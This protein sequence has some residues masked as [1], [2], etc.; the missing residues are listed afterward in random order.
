MALVSLLVM[1]HPFYIKLGLVSIYTLALLLPFTSQFFVPATPIF[2]WL[3]VFYSSQF[4]NKEYRPHIWVSVLPTLESVLYGG[5]I[6]DLLTR[7][8]NPVLDI[9]AW[10]PYGVLHFVLPFV[11][12]A[13]LF[14]F[15]PPGAV[16]FWGAAFGYMNLFGVMI[17][18]AFPCAPPCKLPPA[19]SRCLRACLLPGRQLTLP[20]PPPPPSRRVRAPRRPRARQLRHARLRR[21]PRPD[22]RHLWRARLRDHLFRRARPVRRIPEPARRVLDDGG[23]VHGALLPAGDGFLLCLLVLVVLEHDGECGLLALASS[24]AGR[25]ADPR[26]PQYLTHHY[27]IDLVAGGSLT[28]ICFYYFM[29]DSMR[30]VNAPPTHDNDIDHALGDLEGLGGGGGRSNGF[31]GWNADLSDG[32]DDLNGPPSAVG[33]LRDTSV[34]LRGE[35]RGAFEAIKGRMEGK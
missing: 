34:D 16:K 35:A 18:V 4:L 25:S 14:V 27:L 2:A 26:V 5:N 22:R 31:G 28:V 7:Y 12:A 20:P 19:C 24:Q 3:I 11:V 33:L 23:A 6:S 15:G 21:R 32:E 13:V 8:T 30:N 9:V 17:Q 29:P 1:A 10:I